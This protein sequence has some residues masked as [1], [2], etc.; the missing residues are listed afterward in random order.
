M[1][2]ENDCQD[3]FLQDLEKEKTMVTFLLTA[4]V[5][6]G[7]IFAGYRINMY[8]Y[9]QGAVGSTSR[10]LPSI[11]ETLPLASV[12]EEA[13]LER[14]YG[15]RYARSVLLLATGFTIALVVSLVIVILMALH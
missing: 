7:L 6:S 4:I 15:L 14:D 12:V 3:F 5:L 10:S 1:N 2:C 8:L 11:V 13:D 9:L